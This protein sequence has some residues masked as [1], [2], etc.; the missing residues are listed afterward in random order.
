MAFLEVIRRIKI[1]EENLSSYVMD[2]CML[3]SECNLPNDSDIILKLVL[4]SNCGDKVL[5]EKI[6]ASPNADTMDQVLTIMQ[7]HENAQNE[8]KSMDPRT[9][10]AAQGFQG[11]KKFQKPLPKQSAKNTSKS[12]QKPPP[13]KGKQSECSG[14]GSKVHQYK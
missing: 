4:V 5:Q 12:G 11:K 1:P 13:G 8:V 2:L 10:M 6:C 3:L 7:A 9:S 14:C